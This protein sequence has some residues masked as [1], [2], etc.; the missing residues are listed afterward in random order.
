MKL[1]GKLIFFLT[2]ICFITQIDTTSNSSFKKLITQITRGELSKEDVLKFYNR[3]YDPMLEL[4]KVFTP[5]LEHMIDQE[6]KKQASIFGTIA[7]TVKEIFSGG[8]DDLEMRGL[9]LKVNCEVYISNIISS[10]YLIR[11]KIVLGSLK[12]KLYPQSG[13]SH[14]NSIKN[15]LPYS[16]GEPRNDKK[17]NHKLR[18]ESENFSPSKNG[19]A[20]DGKHLPLTEENWKA[21]KNEYQNLLND[22]TKSQDDINTKSI[23]IEKLTDESCKCKDNLKGLDKKLVECNKGK[24]EIHNKFSQVIQTQVKSVE[25]ICKEK[26]EKIKILENELNKRELNLN[27]CQK[28]TYI[29]EKNIEKITKESSLSKESEKKLKEC[30][31]KNNIIHEDYFNLSN[32]MNGLNKKISELNVKIQVLTD[33]KLKIITHKD[34][35]E[36]E[37]K[38]LKED[39]EIIQKNER[40]CKSQKE[41]NM[42]SLNKVNENYQKCSF[43]LQEINIRLT[44]YTNEKKKET[45]QLEKQLS[46]EKK[47]NNDLKNDLSIK[48]KHYEHKINESRIIIESDKAKLNEINLKLM[49]LQKLEKDCKDINNMLIERHEKEIIQK[50]EYLQQ[51]HKKTMDNLN[52]QFYRINNDC[53]DQKNILI[54]DKEEIEK[55]LKTRLENCERSYKDLSLIFDM[56]KQEKIKEKSE[57]EKCIGSVSTLNADIKILMQDLDRCQ[58][59]QKT[60]PECHKT[61]LQLEINELNGKL[62][63]IHDEN[64]SMTSKQKS[65]IENINTC[66]DEKENLKKQNELNIEKIYSQF[67]LEIKKI[68]ENSKN[69]WDYIIQNS[70]ELENKLIII[71]QENIKLNSDLEKCK[72]ERNYKLDF[73]ACE[74]DKGITQVTI[75]DK[76]KSI[77]TLQSEIDKMNKKIDLEKDMCEKQLKELNNFISQLKQSEEDCK[78]KL[79]EK[80]KKSITIINELK[81]F[82]LKNMEEILNIK[83]YYVLKNNDI[84]LISENLQGEINNLKKRLAYLEESKIQKDSERTKLRETIEDQRKLLF[85]AKRE[86]RDL[87]NKLFALEVNEKDIKIQI[88]LKIQNKD[89]EIQKL[90]KNLDEIVPFYDEAYGQISMIVKEI[91]I[92]KLQIEKYK[93]H[94]TNVITI[95]KD[96][97][98]YLILIDK[99]IND[100]ATIQKNFSRNYKDILNEY[101]PD[102]QEKFLKRQQEQYEQC[103]NEII[104]LNQIIT[105][106]KIECEKDKDTRKAEL[107]EKKNSEQIVFEEKQ[108]E[109]CNKR[110]M[111]IKASG[112]LITNVKEI[113]LQNKTCQPSED[114]CILFIRNKDNIVD[115]CKN[116]E[117]IRK[118]YNNNCYTSQLAPPHIEIKSYSSSNLRDNNHE[119]MLKRLSSTKP[120]K[121]YFR[122]YDFE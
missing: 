96:N 109:A 33:E 11:K 101:S 15:K 98:E 59:N 104:K 100:I 10:E 17:N 115:N 20:G 94:T 74:K 50:I 122:N 111:E 56:C 39:I 46:L 14:D 108:K 77:V 22:F 53:N 65:L 68:E 13:N 26:I 91:E 1:N 9:G 70:R 89:K 82:T 35:C 118:E 27:S 75:T 6:S 90:T 51:D 84:S 83:N 92:I 93:E 38:K 49:T 3:D 19:L 114:L 55:K 107:K 54:K 99:L 24:L 87:R 121:K 86:R 44:T 40:K 7:Q 105:D 71:E 23:Q 60:C 52:N 117:K 85:I 41:E 45:T 76:E 88:E 58:N 73:E 120:S 37:K 106:N 79:F 66:K 116:L 69:K 8:Y 80:D 12:S 95:F 119:D 64:L 2:T 42:M 57:S 48:Q 63:V 112:R 67:K 62:K 25:E 16:D 32:K 97:Q 18:V 78:N 81:T 113:K 34:S 47:N 102:M 31:D 43:E 28:N 36:T 21:L 29:L 30:E 4:H 5:C 61:K 103:Y 110:I 72:G